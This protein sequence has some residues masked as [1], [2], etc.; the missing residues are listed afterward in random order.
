M[1]GRQVIDPP[2]PD[3]QVPCPVVREL[4]KGPL[5]VFSKMQDAPSPSEAWSRSVEDGRPRWG[6]QWALECLDFAFQPIVNIHNGVCFGH[7]ALL[8]NWADAGFESIRNV[9]DTAADTMILNRVES[10]LRE[11]AISKFATIPGGRHLKLFYNL[12]NRCLDMP[13]YRPGMTSQLL[14]HNGLSPTALFLEISEQ[15]DVGRAG[16]L[17]RILTTYR[18]QGYKLVLDDYG[19]GFSQLKMLYHCEPDVIKVDRFFISGMDTDKRKEMLVEQVVDLAH[20]MGTLVVAEGVETE[21]EYYAA[22][23]AGCDLLQGYLVQH[24][25]RDVGLLKERYDYIGALSQR[26]RRTAGG[27]D[28]E[29][30]RTRTRQ[31]QPVRNDATPMSVLHYFREFR[32]ISVVPVVD[33]DLQPIGVIREAD[34]KEFSYSQYGRDLLQN[35]H[36]RPNLERFI[37]RCPAVEISEPIERFLKVFAT[38][39][40]KDGVIV[41]EQIR[42]VGFLDGHALLEM[43]NEKNTIAA[44][45]QNP[46]TQLPGNNA[47]YRYVSEALVH[48]GTGRYFAYFDF[49]NF[50][51]F[52]DRFGF[53]QGDRAI[54]LFAEIMKKTLV[55]GNW[56][57]GHIGGDD[58]FVGAERCDEDELLR[59]IGKL[60]D[61]FCDQIGSF[62]D[63]ES[64]DQGFIVGQDREG[65][66]RQ[67]P[68]MTIS[69]AILRLPDEH[70]NLSVDD[71]V[72]VISRLKKEA[73]CAINHL[74]IGSLEGTDVPPSQVLAA[75]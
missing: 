48:G 61:E 41:T 1:P 30:I 64:R 50:K 20:L 18:N 53:R 34:F 11:K 13:D 55:A 35:P 57:V 54:L 8:R 28:R 16:H 63:A 3:R 71:V 26:D 39:T 65:I 31:V 9:F 24:P 46:L 17:E 66:M 56:F 44:R 60:L 62:Y 42:Y 47:I 27:D 25:T 15:H 67:F 45:D 74:A 37:H 51:P 6:W 19:S 7:E 32:D 43:L 38:A 21:A 40:N 29:L 58:F 23:R 33:D 36:L 52:N 68:L 49:D 4:M 10:C 73:K 75:D 12:D 69:A 2:V 59:R 72:P 5:E 14:E 70:S 22:K